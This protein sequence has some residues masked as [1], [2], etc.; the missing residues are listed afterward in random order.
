MDQVMPMEEIANQ[1]LNSLVYAMTLL[2]KNLKE[3]GVELDK[4][5]RASDRVWGTLGAQAA[6]Q[7]KA[8]FPAPATIESIYQAG[9]MAQAVHGIEVR[10]EVAQSE[11]YT[12]FVSCPWHDAYQALDVPEDWRLCPSGHI[13][14]TESLYSGL[15]PNAKYD[16]SQNMPMG[17][18]V[19]KAKTSL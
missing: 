9:Q 14:F 10:D 3:E 6:D 19:C 7:L 13:A 17:A 2:L 5:K 11:I 12:E 1:R 8:F 16:L 18:A 15:N 4:V